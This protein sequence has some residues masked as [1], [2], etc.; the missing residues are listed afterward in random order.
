MCAALFH[1][2]GKVHVCRIR[3]SSALTGLNLK[4]ALVGFIRSF[5]P[6][7]ASDS[8]TVNGVAPNITSKAKRSSY[9]EGPLK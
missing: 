3:V 5:A 9:Y 6:Q 2:K 7:L 4:H 1:I 8:I